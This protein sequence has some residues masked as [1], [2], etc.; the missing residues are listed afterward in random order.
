MNV[1]DASDYIIWKVCEG[2]EFLNQ[3]KLQKLAYYAE[4]WSWA[5]D[6]KPLTGSPFQ[7]WVH[8][9]V[10]RELFDRFKATKSLYSAMLST[11]IRPEF[12]PEAIDSDE[13][14]HI[15]R[16]LDVYASLTGSQLETMTHQEDPWVEARKGYGPTERCEVEIN[17]ETMRKYYGARLS[18]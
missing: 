11:D 17:T 3:L 7:A 1:L 10:S 4:A 15:D 14:A 2:G 6:G 18:S 8:G 12:N 5:I 9:P 13:R 16:V